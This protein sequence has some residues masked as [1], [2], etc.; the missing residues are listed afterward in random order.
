MNWRRLIAPRTLRQSIVPVQASV[1]EGGATGRIAAINVRFGSK[2]D[3][4]SAQAD[5]R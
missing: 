3:M 1:L 2:A 5:V 4:C